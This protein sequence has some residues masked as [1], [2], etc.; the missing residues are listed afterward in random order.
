MYPPRAA[1]VGV[2]MLDTRFPRPVG[3]IGNPQTLE[4]HG[5]PVRHLVVDGASPSRVVWQADPTLLQPFV[6]AAK[7]L[8][9]G[10]AALITTSCG[11]LVAHQRAI[12]SAVRVPVLTSSLLACRGLA[13]PGILTI[14]AASLGA[15]ILAAAGVAQDTPVQGVAPGCE[16]HRCLLGNE[17]R[18]D[19]VQAERDVLDAAR[20]LVDASPG[21]QDLVLECTN[22]PP[23][24][25]A[26]EQATGRRVHDIETMLLAAW[27]SI[28]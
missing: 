14:D 9:N 21:V 10:G 23:Y 7:V 18:M 27:R 24:R 11:F 2:L 5:I 4:R 3:D 8:A 20:A 15:R 13:H 28:G 12:E 26:I 17:E 25:D 19:F 6:D 16:F 22:M 1:H